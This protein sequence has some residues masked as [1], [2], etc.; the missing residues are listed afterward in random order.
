MSA[1]DKSP[2]DLTGLDFGPAWAKDEKPIRDYS[3]EVGPRE[4]RDRRG[5]GPRRDGGRGGQGGG[6]GRDRRQGGGAGG[7]QGGQNRGDND[8]RQS[9]RRQG[10]R[11]QPDRREGDRRGGREYR[12]R[13]PVVD[14]P[15]GF[16]GSVMPVEEGL[17]NLSREIQAGGRTYS[18]FDLARVVMGA[19]ER[20]NVTF[21]APKGKVMFRCKSDGSI[22]LTQE[23]AVQQFWRG[24]LIAELYEEVAL[25]VEPPKGSFNAIAKCGLSGK[26]LGPPNYHSYPTAVAALHAERFSHMSLEDYKRKIRTESGEEVV[27]A[28]LDS[29]T[30]Q[31]RF[32]PLSSKE[33]L[34]L[35]EERKAAEEAAKA[36]AKKEV[37]T[38]VATETEATEATAESLTEPAPEPEEELA[39]SEKPTPPIEESAEPPSAETE[40]EPTEAPAP[41]EATAETAP[42]AAA[43]VPEATATE[44]QSEPAKEVTLLADRREVE[45]HF[46][47][48][49]FKHLF[50]EVD[51]AW[52]PGNIAAKLLSPALLTLLK[53]TVAEERR[54]PSKLTPVLCRQLSGRHLA[55]FKWKK[56]L[57]AGPARPHAI[58]EDLKLADRPQQILD[59]IEKN[60]SKN[61]EA[62][63]KECLPEGAA[64]ELK[65]SYYHDLHW[66]LNQGYVL[67]MADSTVH[68]AKARVA[69]TPPAKEKQSAAPKEEKNTE[70]K[71]PEEKTPEAEAQVEA[72]ETEE[73]ASPAVA[74]SSEETQPA[75]SPEEAA[76]E[77]VAADE[78]SE[79]KA[80]E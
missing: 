72:P 76:P 3:K 52:V 41:E 4:G 25:E 13:P 6:G 22:W 51:R 54:Y 9:D 63:W 44:E 19:R 33:I 12:E 53:E 11:R 45:R 2:L 10:D 20:F 61:L 49:H 1:E 24:D 21:E 39:S 16:I 66:L 37:S 28:W 32:R 29:M 7:N 43:E 80:P 30:K 73:P 74:E 67:L 56:K 62:L 75:A 58:P 36:P 31:V 48:H 8:R 15:E 27:A 65:H 14:A 79:E 50:V 38:P 69:A 57:K 68:L 17:D 71:T 42:D 70:S 77:A 59:W 55:V 64:D 5:G 35:R 78:V 26:W 40:T 34:A 46:T 60:S 18:V 47:D 23:E